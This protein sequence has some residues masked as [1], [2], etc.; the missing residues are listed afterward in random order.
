L[1]SNSSGGNLLAWNTLSNYVPVLV[2]GM[3]VTLPATTG[4]TISLT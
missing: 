3:S 2:S 1:W 4:L